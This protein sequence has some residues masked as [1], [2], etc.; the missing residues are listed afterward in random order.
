MSPLPGR[1]AAFLFAIATLALPAILRGESTIIPFSY[2]ARMVFDHSG[3]YIYIESP[4]QVLRYNLKTRQMEPA[5]AIGAGAFDIAPDDSFLL[6]ARYVPTPEND[7]ASHLS[8][9][10]LRT[11]NVTD[12]VVGQMGPVLTIAITA[13][14]TALFAFEYAPGLY[15]LNLA[16]GVVRQRTDAPRWT[17]VGTQLPSPV[18]R[19]AAATRLFFFGNAFEE[20]TFTYDSVTDTFSG[21]SDG[22]QYDEYSAVAVS[23]DGRLIASSLYGNRTSFDEPVNF[24]PIRAFRNC[25]GGVVFDPNRDVFYAIDTTTAELVAYDVKSYAELCRIPTGETAGPIQLF[26]SGDSRY[27]AWYTAVG[28]R[29]F[30]LPDPL[31]IQPTKAASLANVQSVAFDHSGKYLYAATVDGA[32]IQYDYPGRSIVKV[33]SLGGSLNGIDIAPDDSF[34]LVG[35]GCPGLLQSVCYKINLHTGEV[36]DVLCPRFYG[37][38]GVSGVA[39]AANGRTFFSAGRGPWQVNLADNTASSRDQPTAGNMIAHSADGAVLYFGAAGPFGPA[40]SSIGASFQT[41]DVRADAFNAPVSLINRYLTDP[42][43]AVSRDGSLVATKQDTSVTF[44]KPADFHYFHSLAGIDG[45]IAFDAKRDLF[46]G[47]DAK[48]GKI[49]AWDTVQFQRQFELDVGEPT[50]ALSTAYGAGTIVASSDGRSLAVITPTNVRVLDIPQ[51]WTPASYPSV[52]S[53]IARDLVFD[54]AGKYLYVSTADGLIQRY[55]VAAQSVDRTYQVGGVLNA[56]DIA[57]DDSFLVI[58]NGVSGIAEAALQKLDVVTGNVT[59]IT[60]SLR[61]DQIGDPAQ[62]G[63]WDLALTSR[64][65]ILFSSDG[66]GNAGTSIRQLD[67][68]SGTI[69]AR[70][71]AH[72][73]FADRFEPRTQIRR[74]A[75][76]RRLYI[77]D[78]GAPGACLYNGDNDTFGPNVSLGGPRYTVALNRDG[79]LAATRMTQDI[80]IDRIPDLNQIYDFIL[81]D[82]V[83]DSPSQAGTGITFDPVADTLYAVQTY[84]DRI[85]AFDSSAFTERYHFEIGENVNPPGYSTNPRFGSGVLAASPDGHHLGLITPTTVHVYDLNTVTKTPGPPPPRVPI[86]R[87]VN[88]STS[89]PVTT[90]GNPA[91]IMIWVTTP[92]PRPLAINYTLSGTAVFGADYLLRLRDAANITFPKTGQVVIPA[93][94]SS[95]LL[96]VLGLLDQIPEGDETVTMTLN[97]GEGYHFVAATAGGKKK[98]K[99]KGAKTPA[100]PHVTIT[101]V[102]RS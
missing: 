50:I 79:S 67:L 57:A 73:E 81:F 42:A 51:T 85:V 65:T 27:L 43:F 5:Y 62:F 82:P 84:S 45:G 8:R 99:S 30:A 80:A 24:R 34:L 64:G 75:D 71:D 74:S 92:T 13:R 36:T 55:D 52:L 19:N 102:N 90:E 40:L 69:S 77:A 39:V 59:N 32:V 2:P 23:R 56:I 96:S 98:K 78:F 38:N 16:T 47:L 86:S 25:G 21:G 88:I 20:L 6:L 48:S 60:Y 61:P 9:L 95:V 22:N 41:Y 1:I 29:I 70:T 18:Y 4:D 53:A 7:F 66:Y 93:G 14:N 44:E 46:Y 10:D 33:Y 63:P 100:A 28:I 35:Q 83:L 37:E 94:Q 17:G 87:P 3:N 49:V 91:D 101:I 76:R 72:G 68:L 11:G 15:E 97:P 26:I 54:H 12:M 58:A 89:D 31:P